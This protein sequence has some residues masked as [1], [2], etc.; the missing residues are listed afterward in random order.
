MSDMDNKI[1]DALTS[2][3]GKF[4]TLTKKVDHLAV[5]QQTM[6]EEIA[7]LKT[8]QREQ[9]QK[10]DILTEKVDQLEAGQQ[11]QGKQLE[12]LT[13]KVEVINANQ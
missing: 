11:E 6:Q 9:G 4:D 3:T 7:D 12:T 10:L 5:G 13:L 8:G 2:L 1:L